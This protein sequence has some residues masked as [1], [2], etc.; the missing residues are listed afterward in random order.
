MLHNLPTCCIV[1]NRNAEIMEIN[2]AASDLLKVKS[3]GFYTNRR[4]ESLLG[5]RFN[6]IMQD[7][8]NGEIIKD[9]EVQFK[10]IDDSLV[11]VQLKTS[12]FPGMDDMFLIEFTKI[13]SNPIVESSQMLSG[14]IRTFLLPVKLQLKKL[15]HTSEKTIYID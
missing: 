2:K 5:I 6:I 13:K 4:L 8:L 10:C 14:S 9:E 3:L 15:F 1:I 7:L 12:L 11:N